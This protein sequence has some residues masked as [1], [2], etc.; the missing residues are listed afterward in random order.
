MGNKEPDCDKCGWV[1][2]ID[3]N[4]AF[5]ELLDKYHILFSNGNGGIQAETI[6]L[7][8]DN[9]DIDNDDFISKVNIYYSNGFRAREDDSGNLSSTSSQIQQFLDGGNNGE[10][11]NGKERR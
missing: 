10:E 3:S 5:I 8:C 2:V 9:E 1:S 11:K 4:I 7:I 6:R